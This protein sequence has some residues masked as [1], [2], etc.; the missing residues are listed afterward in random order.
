MTMLRI[1]FFIW[2]ID[3]PEYSKTDSRA[4]NSSFLFLSSQHLFPTFLLS[5][6]AIPFVASFNP[7]SLR[8][9]LFLSAHFSFYRPHS[10]S[11]GSC[12]SAP[13]TKVLKLQSPP[14]PFFLF[15]S[16]LHYGR[17][18]NAGSLLFLR[19]FSSYI[20]SARGFHNFTSHLA[21]LT[22]LGSLADLFFGGLSS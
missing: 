2:L 1:P 3:T 22:S 7:T 13:F 19:L 4:F 10:E 18:A 9:L 21:Q 15:F 6:R 8:D 5:L 11:C 17:H 20:C 14:A 12:A 16:T